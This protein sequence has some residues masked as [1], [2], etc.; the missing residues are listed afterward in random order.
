MY[1]HTYI[2]RYFPKHSIWTGIGLT[3][4]FVGNIYIYIHLYIYVI[5]STGKLRVSV[6]SFQIWPELILE[7]TVNGCHQ[8]YIYIIMS[9]CVYI[10]THKNNYPHNMYICFYICLHS[11]HYR[12]RQVESNSDRIRHMARYMAS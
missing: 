12:Y 4:L 9:V 6:V 7:I 5:R 11:A 1:I 3:G 2:K 10:Y 8:Q